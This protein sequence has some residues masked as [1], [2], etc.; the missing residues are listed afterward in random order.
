MSEERLKTEWKDEN[1]ERKYMYLF[2]ANFLSKH[3]K[4]DK[5]Q[6]A[7]YSENDKKFKDNMFSKIY[8]CKTTQNSEW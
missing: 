7:K 1:K 2:S 8:R 4:K 6:C 3:E 5:I